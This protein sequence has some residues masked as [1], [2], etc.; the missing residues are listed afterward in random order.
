M[1]APPI[2]KTQSNMEEKTFYLSS[3]SDALS[4]MEELSGCKV[5][6]VVFPYS[7]YNN[8]YISEKGHCYSVRHAAKVKKAWKLKVLVPRDRGFGYSYTLQQNFEQ[9][10]MKAE[11]L[12][13]CTFVIGEWDE[14]IELEFKDGNN[15]NVS[16]DNLAEVGEQ[17]TE[18]SA[19]I[20]SEYADIYRDKY[21]YVTK[22]VRFK[23][24]VSMEDAEDCTSKTFIYLTA[25]RRRK[26]IEDFVALWIHYAVKKAQSLWLWRYIPRVGRIDEKEWLFKRPAPEHGLA[27]LNVLPDERWKK[28]MWCMVNGYSQEETAQE[29]G[30]SVSSVRDFRRESKKYLRNYL[31]TDRE[32][33]KIYG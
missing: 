7:G 19:Q 4:M 28:V 8:Y 27:L 9:I 23:T 29:I 15:H 1:P 6:Q 33:M 13:Y 21:D 22:F 11:K 14:D 30:L 12:V 32:I 16:L 2:H 25:N 5:L 31:S 3:E 20:M 18:E 26:E 17:L 10:Q 24:E